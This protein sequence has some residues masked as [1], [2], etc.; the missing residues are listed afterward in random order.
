MEKS[1]QKVA[2]ISGASGGIGTSVSKRLS[3]DGFII[4]PVSY[5][6]YNITDENTIKEV[7][8]GTVKKYGAINVCIHTAISPIVRKKLL[9]ININEFR[10]QYEVGLFGGFIFM[11]EIA[12]AMK[13]AGQGGSIIAISSSAIE[14]NVPSGG[15][16]G[17][18]SAKFALRGLLR[19]MSRELAPL[20]IRVNAIA[21]GFI[22][23]S[24]NK[25]IPARMIEFL[26]EKNPFKK[27]VT[28]D[29]IAN[30]VSFLVSDKSEAIT[31]LHIPVTY[32]ENITL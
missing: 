22:D 15:M 1:K 9:D 13:N 2:I 5:P 4:V 10:E 18:I 21:P 30:L 16:I 24:L 14:P 20:N 25:D 19:E 12:K 23:T 7:I 6:E 26:K 11:Q 3:E 27:M 28:G 29:D 8:G 17:Y 32:G 31:G